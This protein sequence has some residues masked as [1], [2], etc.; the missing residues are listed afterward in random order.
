MLNLIVCIKWVPSTQSVPIDRRTGTLIREGIPGVVNPPDLNAL[1]LALR[2]KDEYGADVTAVSM[3]PPSARAG[4]EYAVGMGVDRGFLLSDRVFAGAD[5]L[6]TSYTLAKFIER[7]KYD[8]L[9]FGQETT[10][11]ST[12]H[13]GAQ[14]AS[15]LGIP[16]LYYVTDVEVRGDHLVAVRTLED[17]RERYRIRMPAAISVAMKSNVPREVKL[18]NKIRARRKGVIS[19][20]SNEDLELDISCVGLRGSPTRV[21]KI[22]I[23]PTVPRK[24]EIFRGCPDEAAKWLAGKLEEEG[25]I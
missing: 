13:I 7:Q 10:D 23:V 12:G 9:L 19:I 8:L 5:T 16:F 11:S 25:L 24:K 15:W 4:L 3:G 18:A 2:I 1:E 21:S 22:D 14:V 20:M 6:A 17:A